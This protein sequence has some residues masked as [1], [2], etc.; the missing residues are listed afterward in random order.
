MDSVAH[1][2]RVVSYERKL[3]VKSAA[4]RTVNRRTNVM[5]TGGII[6]SYNLTGAFVKP[7]RI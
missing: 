1:F 3:F 4:V 2:A 7:T 5:A 6:I